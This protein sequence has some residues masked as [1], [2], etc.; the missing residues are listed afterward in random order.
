MAQPI[1]F[2]PPPRD[3]RASRA[4]RLAAAPAEHAE[5]VLA[6]YEVLQGLHDRGILDLLRGTLGAGDAL[7]EVAVGAANTPESI[8]ALRNLL[9]VV[10]TLGAIEP[11]LLGDFTRAVPDALIQAHAEE[12]KPP[13]LLKLFRTFFKK[14]FR[15][16]LAAMNALLVAFGRNLSSVEKR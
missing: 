13:G 16:G 14:D 5:A 10:K 1:H 8:R 4:A 12:A 7:V 15:R 9:L 3:P 2:E 6:A 11:A